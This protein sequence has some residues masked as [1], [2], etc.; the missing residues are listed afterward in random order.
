[1]TK[2]MKRISGLKYFMLSPINIWG[3]DKD[4]LELILEF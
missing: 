1:M 4:G 2:S 3:E